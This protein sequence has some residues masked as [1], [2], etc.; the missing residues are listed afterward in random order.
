[1]NG[2]IPRLLIVALALGGTAE[3]QQLYKSVT[4]SG[5]VVYS[6]RP[7]PEAGATV[8]S[9][10][11]L[12][13][14]QLPEVA[15]R[16]REQF[17]K[18]IGPTPP[19]APLVSGEVQLYSASWCRYCRQAKAWLTQQRIAYREF[20][21]DTLI[22]QQAQARAGGGKSVPFIVANGKRLTG[23]SAAGYQQLFGSAAR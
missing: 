21:V 23:F 15:L 19:S 9:V 11:E 13:A 16:A 17:L 18:N 1:M 20:D 4:P 5:Q 8:V 6:D 14:S 7:V 10:V 2:S 3:A 12:P 22:G